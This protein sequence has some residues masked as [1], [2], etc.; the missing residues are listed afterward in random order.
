MK[1]RHLKLDEVWGSRKK[2]GA[3]R[4]YMSIRVSDELRERLELLAMRLRSRGYTAYAA[5]VASELV[6]KGV[7]ALEAGEK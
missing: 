7:D 4:R 6:E 1:S 2:P 3:P 5:T